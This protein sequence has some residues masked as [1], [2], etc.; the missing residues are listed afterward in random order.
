M[1]QKQEK[2][3]RKNLRRIVDNNSPLFTMEMFRNVLA[4]PLKIR[5]L[6]ALKLVFRFKKKKTANAPA[7]NQVMQEYKEEVRNLH[8]AR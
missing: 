1:S 8:I 3:Y 7:L 6:V 2:R 4:M 5:I